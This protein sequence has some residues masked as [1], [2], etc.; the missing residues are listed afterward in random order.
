MSKDR[1]Q[2]AEAALLILPEW[3]LGIIAS[4]GRSDQSVKRSEES[5][6]GRSDRS[7]KRSEESSEDAVIES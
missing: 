4:E 7:V 6:E 2:A 3:K 5:S 1:P